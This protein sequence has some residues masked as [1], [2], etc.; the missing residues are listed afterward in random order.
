M[1]SELHERLGAP[2]RAAPLWLRASAIAQDRGEASDLSRRACESYLNG[3]DVDSARRVL[4]GMG[5]WAQSPRLLELT[6]LIERR[7]HLPVV[8]TVQL[9]T[10]IDELIDQRMW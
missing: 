4:E 1:L 8:D 10:D 9:R 5:A 3:G 2:L 7:R 6:V